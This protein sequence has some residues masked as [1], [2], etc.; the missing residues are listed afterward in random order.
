MRLVSVAILALAS[1]VTHAAQSEAPQPRTYEAAKQLKLDVRWPGEV[2][3]EAYVIV[4]FDVLANGKTA[5]VRVADGGF[6]EKRF[7]DAALLAVRR[8]TW[9]PRRLNGVAVDS[10]G[11]RKGIR[12][13]IQ[14]MEPGVTKEFLD[15]ARKVEDLL[16][17]GDFAG[18][19]FHAQWMLAEKVTLNYEYALLQAQLAQT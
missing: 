3:R 13:S 17:K 4:E 6:H 1:V 9:Q 12:F 8:S 16:K 5:N 10:P 2:T 14:E 11:M 18:G 7:A 19:E 15:E